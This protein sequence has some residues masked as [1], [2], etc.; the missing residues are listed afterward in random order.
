[1]SI[2]K[3]DAEL[4]RASDSGWSDG[5]IVSKATWKQLASRCVQVMSEKSERTF[6]GSSGKIFLTPDSQ[7]LANGAGSGHNISRS[8]EGSLGGCRL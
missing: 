1:M 2:Q 4:G 8:P 6:V 5:K 7:A 3:V